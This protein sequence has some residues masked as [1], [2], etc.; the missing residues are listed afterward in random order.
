MIELGTELQAHYNELVVG[1]SMLVFAMGFCRPVKE[2]VRR[3]QNNTC[4]CC[5]KQEDPLSLHH[6]R[7][8]SLGG[9]SQNIA[10]AVGLC[11]ECHDTIDIETFNGQPYP[12]V[13]DDKN[14]YPQGNK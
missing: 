13:H 5:G 4:D 10:N 12:Q 7:P 14:Y 11:R 3:R 8:A 1:M 2:E 9:S 6:I